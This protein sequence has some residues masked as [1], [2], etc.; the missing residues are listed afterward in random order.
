MRS[1]QETKDTGDKQSDKAV[2]GE[3]DV[4]EKQMEITIKETGEYYVI[5]KNRDEAWWGQKK[6]KRKKMR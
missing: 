5:G 6:R 1:Q 3:E 2:D 4:N